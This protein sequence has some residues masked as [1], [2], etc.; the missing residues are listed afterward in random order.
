AVVCPVRAGLLTALQSEF[1]PVVVKLAINGQPAGDAI[2]ALRNDDGRWWLPAA[3]LTDV[4]VTLQGSEHRHIDDADY[5]DLASMTPVRIEFDDA[6]QA[7]SVTLPASRFTSTSF[8]AQTVSATAADSRPSGAFI[9]YDLFVD[10]S[11]IGDGRSA[12]TEA[13]MA[14]GPGVAIASFAFVRQPV[15]DTN[16]RLDTSYTTDQPSRMTTLRV[17]D[18][19]SRPP[20]S[21]GR[22]VRFAGLQ[23]GTNFLT[24]P[25]LVTVPVPTL[26]GQ[27][28]LPSTVDLYVN[29]VLQSR[30]AAA[31]GPF[32]VTTA[33][34]M[35]GDGELLLKVTDLSGREQVISQRYYASAALLAP[36]LS[37]WSVEAGALRLNYGLRSDD[38]GDWFVSGGWRR[39]LSERLTIEGGASIQQGGR[40]GLLG[41]ASAAIAELGAASLAIGASHDEQG[42]GMQAALGVE[43][44]TRQHT[45]ALRTQ[46]AGADYRQTGVPDQ[47][48][49]RRLDTFFYGYRLPEL[50]S[51]SLSWTRQERAGQDALRIAQ[52]GLSTRQS[53]W[54][55]LMLT[56]THLDGAAHDRSLN[57][58]W[59]LPID[60]GMH[61]SVQ[62]A[63]NDN[64]PDQTVFQFQKVPPPGEGLGYR[65]Q[66]GINVPQQ[67]ALTVQ[68]LHGLLR[69]EAA[70]Y[71]GNTALR[72]GLSGSLVLMDGSLFA[73]RRVD[74][75]FGLVR[76]PGLAG[77]RVYVDNQLAGR[78]D[79]EGVALL[80]RLAPYLK[81][82]VSV[83]PLDL[84]LDVQIDA[85]KTEPVPAWRSGVLIDFPLRTVSAATLN[86]MLANGQPVPAGAELRL[87]GADQED[88]MP[89]GHQGLVYVTG[90]KQFNRLLV[91]WPQGRCRVEIPYAPQK[92]N[93]PYLGEFTCQTMLDDKP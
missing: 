50:G 32:S 83:E 38:Y 15:L 81:N 53:H 44:R 75:S 57:L 72:A 17:G 77:V 24:Q 36:G 76:L 8:Q 67:A 1:M 70:D 14:L 26:Y 78:T 28:A 42:S 21:V 68:N 88:S 58:F 12:F 61:A 85:L 39:G 45:L 49:L 54:G 31:P 80:P 46:M 74:S 79:A 48:Q 71:K 34:L 51:I 6:Q 11:D 19:I 33:P 22:P 40:V 47:L 7:L 10:H 56:L 3:S 73:V 35:S 52:L 43:R 92:G 65:L 91:T 90:L 29:N 41:G 55:S 84:P 27:A 18:A 82:R 66:S 16:L 37:D 93:I 86:L 62:H 20:T 64:G 69:A 87:E 23:F 89:V 60:G 13:G 2:V 30:N 63:H 25:G 5:I 4:R 59:I 9:N